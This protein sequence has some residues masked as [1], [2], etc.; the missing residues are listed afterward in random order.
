MPT[1]SYVLT[2][3][4]YTLHDRPDERM[5][6]RRLQK[7]GADVLELNELLQIALG[8]VDGFEKVLQE[9]GASFLTTLHTVA[10]IT[11]LTGLD[12]LQAT[13]LLAI[14][15]L[16]KRLYAPNYG[17]LPILRGPQDVY[18][19]LRSM[20]YLPTEQLRLLLVNSRFQLVHEQVLAIGRREHLE[21]PAYEVLQAP[22]ERRVT[23]FILVHNHPSGDATPSPSDLEFT[24]Q[25]RKAAEFMHHDLLDH[26]II[27]EQGYSSCMSEL[28]LSSQEQ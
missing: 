13:R 27:A 24:E 21:I 26:V 28:K 15:G 20:A 9:Y 17:S 18:N 11:E 12:H 23:A 1:T 10:E 3:H 14:L 19:H 22:V 25:I 16:G 6:I 7:E 4:Y 8:K 5:P 2:D